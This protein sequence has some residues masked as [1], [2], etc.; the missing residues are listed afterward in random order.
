MNSCLSECS[1]LSSSED[2]A[3]LLANKFSSCELLYPF[4]TIVRCVHESF[5]TLGGASTMVKI[6]RIY[7]DQEGIVGARITIGG[8]RASAA[9]LQTLVAPFCFDIRSLING[10]SI[11]EPVDDFPRLNAAM[12]AKFLEKLYQ[13]HLHLEIWPYH[14]LLLQ[15]YST[16]D[17][18]YFGKKPKEL[19]IRKRMIESDDLE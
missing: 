8:L 16:R 5:G 10:G 7:V 14:V 4:P 12:E 17:N 9:P 13:G 2:I 1:S 6:F 11:I 19:K 15:K 18:K 3:P